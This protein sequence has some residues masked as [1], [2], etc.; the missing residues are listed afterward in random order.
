MKHSYRS[1]WRRWPNIL[2]ID[3]VTLKDQGLYRCRVDYRNIPTKNMVLN[4][5]VVV[6]LTVPKIQ[7]SDRKY[8]KS[9][10]SLGPFRVGYEKFEIV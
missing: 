4:L 2:E 7:N 1:G 9:G 6:P 10:T 3:N 5:S 8:I